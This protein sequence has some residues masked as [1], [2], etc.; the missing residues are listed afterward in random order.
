MYYE[1]LR[2][3][4]EIVNA[5]YLHI[6]SSKL[7]GEKLGM[8]WLLNNGYSEINQ[9]DNLLIELNITKTSWKRPL[10]ILIKI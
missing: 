7:R 2:Q 9:C 6:S 8:K 5:N 4:L 3:V 10:T 1:F